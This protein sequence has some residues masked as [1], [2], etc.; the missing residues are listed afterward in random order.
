MEPMQIDQE[1]HWYAMRD[2]KRRNAVLPAYKLLE[3]VGFDVFTPLVS[4]LVTQHGRCSRCEVPLMQDLLFVRGCRHALDPIVAKTPTLQ[5]RFR[6]GGKSGEPMVIPNEQMNQFIA[7][8][9]AS[10]DPRFYTAEEISS[11]LG[12]RKIRLIGGPLDGCEG[13][14][15]SVRGSKTKRVIITLPSLLAVSIAIR[16]EYVEVLRAVDRAPHKTDDR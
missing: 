13:V 15:Q 16:D 7:A 1:I 2:L 10:D 14:L 12:G 3:Q 11:K 4:Q 8:V 5:Y 6:R 9:S